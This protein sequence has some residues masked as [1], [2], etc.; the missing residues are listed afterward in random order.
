MN[1]NLLKGSIGIIARMGS[2]R[3]LNK[4]L[5]QVDAKPIIS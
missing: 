5:I 3:L 1:E 2:Q 4:H